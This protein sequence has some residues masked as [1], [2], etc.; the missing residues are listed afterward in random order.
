MQQNS[1]TFT[2]TQEQLIGVLAQINARFCLDQTQHAVIILQGE[3]GSGKTS[4]CKAL[5]DFLCQ[6]AAVRAKS[7]VTSPTFSLMNEYD[8]GKRRLFHYD[9]YRCGVEGIVENGLFENLFCE[10]IHL[11]EWG[12]ERLAGRLFRYGV[13]A[14]L[15]RITP[16]GEA[17]RYEV[18]E[19]VG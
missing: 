1:L 12:D 8:A 11:V 16:A 13:R 6:K 10:G 15:L 3:L 18:C 2:A 19:F 17:R 14:I 4:F 7:E 9:I 5:Y